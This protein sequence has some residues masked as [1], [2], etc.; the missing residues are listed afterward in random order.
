MASSDPA[1]AA[2]ENQAKASYGVARDATA[3]QQDLGIGRLGLDDAVFRG[4]G[5]PSGRHLRLLAENRGELFGTHAG[6]LG[7]GDARR[8]GG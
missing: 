7:E 8:G 2:T 3:V 5:E 4:G 6:E 1:P